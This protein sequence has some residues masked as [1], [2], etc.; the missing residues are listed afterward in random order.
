MPFS[1]HFR[2]L[3]ISFLLTGLLCEAANESLPAGARQAGMGGVGLCL[4]DVWSVD[5]NAAALAFL[6][7]PAAGAFLQQ[8]FLVK[9]MS[10]GAAVF[11]MPLKK[12]GTFG[13]SYQYYGF[14][15]YRDTRASLSYSRKFGPLFSAGMQLSYLNTFIGDNYGSRSALAAEVSFLAEVI[16]DLRLG[17]HLYNP[18]RVKTG[19]YGN[20]RVPTVLR[21]GMGYTFNNKVFAGMEVEKDLRNRAVFRAGLEYHILPVLC[22]RAGLSTQPGMSSA[23]MGIRLKSIRVD[24]SFSFHPQLGMTPGIGFGSEG[25][26]TEEWQSASGKW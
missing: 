24:F 11:A 22:L 1:R 16:K 6:D 9:E 20:E 5:H 17:V 26:K 3:L 14:K 8:Q 2:V 23:G 21:V 4:P 13:L 19:S 7:K 15:L 18:T 25:K 10:R 12:I